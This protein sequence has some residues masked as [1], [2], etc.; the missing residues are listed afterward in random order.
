MLED[1]PLAEAVAR[2]DA[3]IPGRVLLLGRSDK[4]VSAAIAVADA[5]A[6]LE[7]IAAREGLQVEA[8]PGV[9]MVVH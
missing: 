1:A 8:I 3:W 6:A 7:A 2:L 5:P 4:R 9:V